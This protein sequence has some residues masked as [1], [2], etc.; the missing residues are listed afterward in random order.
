MS[1]EPQKIKLQKMLK[2]C[3]EIL[4]PMKA[5]KWAPVGKNAIY[6]AIKSG[7]LESY[8]YKGG[9]IISK[10]TLIDYLVK[11]SDEKGRLFATAEVVD[12]DE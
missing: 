11:T 8:V 4:T 7:E 3:P 6:S 5:A 9:Y 10:D 1:Q 2:K 12:N